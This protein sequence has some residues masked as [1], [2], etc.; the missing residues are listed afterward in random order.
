VVGLAVTFDLGRVHGTPWGTHVNEAVVEWPISP[1]RIMRALLASSYANAGL[2]PERPTLRDALRVLASAPPPVFVVPATSAAHTRHYYPLPAWSPAAADKTSLVIDAFLAIDPAAE[3]QVRWEAELSSAE[4]G[5]LERS[6]AA[7]GYLGRSE[8]VCT[9]RVIDR[10]VGQVNCVPAASKPEWEAQA[11]DVDLWS[12]SADTLEALE[13]SVTDLRKA[14]RLTPDGVCR[15]PYL[16]RDPTCTPV[17]TVNAVHAPTLAHLRMLGGARPS[18]T[19][20]VEVARVLRAA[21]QRQFDRVVG[22]GASMVLSGHD[23]AGAV[24]RDQ[25]QHAHYLVGSD[26][27]ALRA[28][29]LWVWAPGGLGADELAAIASLRELRF[30]GAPEPCRVGLVALGD[31]QTMG[32]RELT[33]PSAVWRSVTPFVL[34]RHQKRRGGRLVDGPHEQIVRELAHRGLPEPLST[35]LAPGAW[36]AFRLTTLGVSRRTARHAVGAVLRFP[37]PVGGPIVIGA[38]SHFG[39]GRFEPLA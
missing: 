22:G 35:E 20:T 9:I 19:D 14:R 4:R 10:I 12:V 1:W 8:S 17:T 25:H 16:I 34:P 7:V 11:R 3:L 29:H 39:L 21:L 26:R 5:A 2:I 30:R 36:G 13:V 24:R 28:D 38:H 31:A 33:G 23:A 37:E 15:V 27:D 18:L 32:I 6:A